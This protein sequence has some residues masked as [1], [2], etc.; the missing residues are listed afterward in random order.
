MA[1]AG[2]GYLEGMPSTAAHLAKSP[3]ATDCAIALVL[4]LASLVE[5]SVGVQDPD[6]LLVAVA[7][8][9]TAPVAARRL[10]PLLSTVAVFAPLWLLT[11]SGTDTVVFGHLLAMLLATYTLAHVGTLPRAS[12][13]LALALATAVTNSAAAPGTQ[14]GDYAFPVILL[15]GPWFAGRGLRLWQERTIELQ[16]LNAELEE[17]REESAAL[18]V[19][20]ERGLIARELH[21][22]LAQSLQVIVVNADAAD[23]ALDLDADLA[24]AALGR[25]RS[26][27]REALT[28][29]RQTLGMLRSPDGATTAPRLA[30]LDRLAASVR[31]AGLDVV[32]RTAGTA[33][34]LPTQVD[35]AAYR[36]IQ[37]C[38]TNVLKHA[39]AGHAWVDV[40]YR[41]DRLELEVTDDGCGAGV[42]RAS[43]GHGLLGMRERTLMLGGRLA[44]GRNEGGGFRVHADLPL[45]EGAS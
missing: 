32:V 37:E 2:H 10:L 27:G 39:A 16:R 42:A 1:G 25:I 3:L 4:V 33:R 40:C 36:I 43:G 13:G 22:S 5:L 9:G 15:A 38:L 28:Q 7:V 20:A 11:L 29:T 14:V 31:S 41:D 6:P 17:R 23:A 35:L 24:R 34:E 19:A 45:G 8:L 30:D 12:L 18:A 21:D 44:A 26:Q